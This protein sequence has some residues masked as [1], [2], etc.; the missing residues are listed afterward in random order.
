MG[1]IRKIE[2]IE[3]IKEEPMVIKKEE[4]E[5]NGNGDDIPPPEIMERIR[6][7]LD[8][9][10]KCKILVAPGIFRIVVLKNA[11]LEN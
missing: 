3:E 7:S 4:K 9:I 10:P 8:D 6:D 5:G 11:R 1:R 2:G